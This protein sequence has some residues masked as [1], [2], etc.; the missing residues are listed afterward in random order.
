MVK[1]FAEIGIGNDTFL[2]TEIEGESSEYRI[3]RF[4]L[5]KNI[6]EYYFRFWV[7]NTVL[8]FSSKEGF[9]IKK[10]TKNNFKIL[11]GIGGTSTENPTE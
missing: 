5:P 3:S 2:S 4:S 1:V 7:F 11:F 6:D 10:K 9:K 8:I